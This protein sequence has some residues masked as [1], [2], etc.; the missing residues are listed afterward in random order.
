M[1]EGGNYSF[2]NH[3]LRTTATKQSF[4]RPKL[5][6]QRQSQSAG[7]IFQSSSSHNDTPLLVK[8][9][10][11]QNV[12]FAP[13]PPTSPRSNSRPAGEVSPRV[14]ALNSK[15]IKR[16]RNE[17]TRNSASG[18]EDERRS[19][20]HVANVALDPLPLKRR[21]STGS[22]DSIGSSESLGSPRDRNRS[23]NRNLRGI[24]PLKDIGSEKDLVHSFK[25]NQNNAKNNDFAKKVLKKN[26]VH[27]LR[28]EPQQVLSTGDSST[29]TEST[30]I[31]SK[32]E[33]SI[34]VKNETPAED[35]ITLSSSNDSL[36]SVSDSEENSLSVS[37]AEGKSD[38]KGNHRHPN[39]TL[40]TLPDQLNAKREGVAS[41]DLYESVTIKA[42]NHRE[43]DPTKQ[44]L[45]RTLKANSSG[46]YE[47]IHPNEENQDKIQH[48]SAS[49]LRQLSKAL[50]QVATNERCSS[51]TDLSNWPTGEF[52][53][54]A[55]SMVLPRVSARRARTR[56]GNFLKEEM[57]RYLPDRKI[58]IFVATWNMHEEK[59]VPFYLDDFL[60][61]DSTDFLQD[62]YVIGLQESTSQRKEWEIRL[63]ETLGP[64]HVLMY[65]CS[66][67]LL[68]LAIFI[69]RELVWFCSA[70]SEDSVS[71][72]VGHM[73]KTK[74]ALAVSFSIFGTSF[75]FIDSHF[76][77]DEGK[78]LDRVNDYKTICKSLSLSPENQ[79]D[80]TNES[81]LTANFDRVFWLGD[82]NFRVTLGRSEVDE[83]LEKYKDQENPEFKDLLAKD[84][85]LDLREQGKV[86]VGFTEPP[87]RFLPSYK[88]DIQSDDYDSSSK[89]RTPS[90]TDRVLYRSK[91]PSSIQ[92]VMYNS[93]V[94]VKTSDHRPVFGIYQV[95]LNP[96][97]ENIPLTGGQFT[98][99]VYIEANRRRSLGPKSQGQSSVC[100]IL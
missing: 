34:E 27:P 15:G 52:L 95:K 81:D 43:N 25:S 37:D 82:F 36:T 74:G 60:I 28:V 48:N 67:G 71:T 58:G 10:S 38:G 99:D 4:E 6:H 30:W 62:L 32:S 83:M 51:E 13:H 59:E 8:E 100:V 33:Q 31:H 2:F 69:R 14:A 1:A 20:K 49:D 7:N 65:S 85:L 44:G 84:Q 40:P 54:S 79:P 93:C 42:S 47:N 41:A 22:L 64:S 92:P 11:A 66:F 63:Q 23:I 68:H 75:L 29:Q 46:L 80:R 12:K 86:F 35:E 72:R 76:T 77:S 78:V 19:H 50:E 89:N 56:S 97:G 18:S 5:L 61:P 87:I 91:D 39:S 3:N 88:H 45:G 55:T 9:A 96:C 17:S 24:E 94:S 21:G 26:V 53:S 73:I 16:T 70:V 98:R 90:W 57:E